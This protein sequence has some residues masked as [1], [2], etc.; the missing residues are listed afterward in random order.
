MVVPAPTAASREAG[1]GGRNGRAGALHGAA[2]AGAVASAW[3]VNSRQVPSPP[4][5]RKCVDRKP[6][7][8]TA[9]TAPV[10]VSRVR[11]RVAAANDEA[12]A[13]QTRRNSK[14]R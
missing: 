14:L 4:T 3:A 9:N 13:T 2:T 10:D 8:H 11:A 12:D 5:R 6:R 1:R 7:C